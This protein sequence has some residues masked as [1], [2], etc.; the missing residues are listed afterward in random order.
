MVVKSATN[1]NTLLRRGSDVQVQLEGHEIPCVQARVQSVYFSSAARRFASASPAGDC[2]VNPLRKLTKG[3]DVRPLAGLVEEVV[4]LVLDL[5]DAA[6][7]GPTLRGERELDLTPVVFARGPFHEIRGDESVDD[8]AGA[9]AG[10]ADEHVAELP[11]RERSVVA[12]DA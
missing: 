12:D 1:S 11:E 3:V 5:Y 10:V 9:G 6:R 4:Q 8:A 7:L 2:R